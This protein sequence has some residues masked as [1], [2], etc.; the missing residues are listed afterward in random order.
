MMSGKYYCKTNEKAFFNI[1]EV[2]CSLWLVFRVT[3]KEWF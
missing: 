3:N 2:K 1:C